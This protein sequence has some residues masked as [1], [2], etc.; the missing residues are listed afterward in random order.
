[1]R[2]NLHVS[3]QVKAIYQWN[4]TKDGKEAGIWTVDLKNGDG[5]LYSGKAKKKAGCTITISDDDFVAMTTGELDGMKAF[6]SGKM[7]VT[8]NIM[9]A[10]KLSKIF[11]SSPAKAKL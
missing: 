2:F 11:D 6:M 4:I 7:K 5:E 3:Q 1:M 8:G 9:L 10:Q